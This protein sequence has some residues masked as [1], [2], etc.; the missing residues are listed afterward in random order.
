MSNLKKYYYAKKMY[1][2]QLVLLFTVF[3]ILG[4][5]LFI[6]NNNRIIH[7]LIPTI[8]T[9]FFII[10]TPIAFFVIRYAYFC[11][12]CGKM[13]GRITLLN[14]FPNRCKHCGSDLRVKS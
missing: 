6:G 2:F 4:F 14:F 1:K 12:V 10:Y 13:F 3:P 5:L 8:F 11:P 9:I 7:E